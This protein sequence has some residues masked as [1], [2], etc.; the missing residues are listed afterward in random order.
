MNGFFDAIFDVLKS[1]A[2]YSSAVRLSVLFAFC[3]LGETIAERA[4]TLNISTNGMILGGSFGAAVGYNWTGSTWIGLAFAAGAGLLVGIVHA[5][6][7]H[8][9]TLNTFVVGLALNILVLGLVTFLNNRFEPSSRAAEIIEIPLLSDI[10]LI[11]Q[12]LFAQPWPLYL[13]YPL[14]P[15]SYWM[16]YRLRWGL[17][18]RSVGENPQSAYVSGIDVNKRRRQGVYISGLFSGLGGGYLLLGM[19]G[20]F[21]ENLVGDRG[22]IAIAAVI[23]GGWTLKGALAG[24]LLFG[25]VDS[26]RL[27]I[28]VAGHDVNAE[29]LQGLPFFITIV[30]VSLIA[31]KARQPAAL[32]RPF[33]RG[34][35]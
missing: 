15:L 7:S 22:F 2:T 31:H 35:T 10:P 23:F 29:L 30:T 21:D 24:C 25:A 20:R 19:I 12:A 33:E 13:I 6:L 17:E 9:L 8:R 27:S 16:L 3:A 34:L 11:G 14:I 4:G 18:I 26:F 5:N 32:A 1:E 28:P